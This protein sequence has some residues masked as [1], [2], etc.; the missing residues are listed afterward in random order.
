M[1]VTFAPATA[2][3]EAIHLPYKIERRAAE[4]YFQLLAALLAHQNRRVALDRIEADGIGGWY[5][6]FACDMATIELLR[7]V[8]V[9]IGDRSNP[10]WLVA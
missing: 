10:L 8:A 4:L 5:I 2:S 6:H 3:V 1:T 9:E 7:E